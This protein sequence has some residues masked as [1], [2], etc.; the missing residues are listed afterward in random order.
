MAVSSFLNP[1]EGYS[2]ELDLRQDRPTGP[3]I[4]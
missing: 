1:L 3:K 2:G 4:K